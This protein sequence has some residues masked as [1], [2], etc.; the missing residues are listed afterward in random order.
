LKRDIQS[1]PEHT[2]SI[3]LVEA[4][5]SGRQNRVRMLLFWLNWL[6]KILFANL[7]IN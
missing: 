1:F 3:E 6:C 4:W 2:E 7:F 5:F